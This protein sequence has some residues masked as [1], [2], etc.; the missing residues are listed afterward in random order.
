[1]LKPWDSRAVLTGIL[2]KSPQDSTYIVYAMLGC[3][4]TSGLEYIAPVVIFD[5]TLLE[6][7][8]FI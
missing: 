7:S 5:A 4:R 3:P 2:L 6:V 1:M 8:V